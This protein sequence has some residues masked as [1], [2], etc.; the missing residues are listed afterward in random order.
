MIDDG[1]DCVVLPAWGQSSD[2]IHSD[3]FE[4]LRILLGANPV[5][6]NS[7]AMR[8]DF[9]LLA[10]G[11]SFD[12]FCYP[13]LRSRPIIIAVDQSDHF[14]SSRMS[15]CRGVVPLFHDLSSD[16]VIWGND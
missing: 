5:R 4:R 11:A 6:R 10:G 15:S 12:V 14:V 16:I 13:V 7:N 9:V 3:M 8:K 2:E 1:E